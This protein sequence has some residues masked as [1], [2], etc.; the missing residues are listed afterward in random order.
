M[1]D[2]AGRRPP[3]LGHADRNISCKKGKEGEA[4]PEKRH[5]QVESGRKV[6]WRLYPWHLLK[7][8]AKKQFQAP[9]SQI[10]YYL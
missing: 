2:R 9:H 1:E 8:P 6:N 7:L 4:V 3:I 10:G 5:R